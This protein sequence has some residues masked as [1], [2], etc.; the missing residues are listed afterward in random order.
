MAQNLERVKCEIFSLSRTCPMDAKTVR[1]HAAWVMPFFLWSYGMQHRDVNY[2]A[3]KKKNLST[4]RS[5]L[6]SY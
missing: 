4:R 5:R 1:F 3:N 2:G 6:N